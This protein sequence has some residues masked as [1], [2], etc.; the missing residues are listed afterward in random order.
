M[1]ATTLRVTYNTE[2]AKSLGG[3]VNKVVHTIR[4]YTEK[5]NL[6]LFRTTL[7]LDDGSVI[8]CVFVHGAVIVDVNKPS[9]GVSGKV[10]KVITEII[11]YRFGIDL[12]ASEDKRFYVSLVLGKDD[13]KIGEDILARPQNDYTISDEYYIAPLYDFI[14][15][16]CPSITKVGGVQYV[17]VA[18][19]NVELSPVDKWDDWHWHKYY[20]D[21]TPDGYEMSEELYRPPSKVTSDSGATHFSM[22]SNT[23]FR[24]HEIVSRYIDQTKRQYAP[25]KMVTVAGAENMESINNSMYGRN[26][27]TLDAKGNIT[28]KLERVTL[29]SVVTP[30]VTEGVSA[31]QFFWPFIPYLDEI[32]HFNL[33]AFTRGSDVKIEP[34]LESMVSWKLHYLDAFDVDQSIELYSDEATFS[35][36]IPDGES[37]STEEPTTCLCAVAGVETFDGLICGTGSIV[38]TSDSSVA[39]SSSGTKYVPIGTGGSLKTLHVKNDWVIA[40]TGPV[41]SVNTTSVTTGNLPVVFH[42]IGQYIDTWP[43]IFGICDYRNDSTTDETYTETASNSISITQEL[44]FGDDIIDTGITTMQYSMNYEEERTYTGYWEIKLDGCASSCTGIIGYTTTQM[45]VGDTQTLTVVDAVTGAT[46]SWAITAGGGSLSAATG[47][48]TVY[49][50]PATNANCSS[51]PTISLSCEIAAVGCAEGTASTVVDTL[52]IA[53]NANATTDYAYGIK[54]NYTCGAPYSNGDYWCITVSVY[55]NE[56]K[57]DGTLKPAGAWICTNIKS[58]GNACCRKACT[59]TCAD[60]DASIAY[61]FGVCTNSTF[62]LPV[63]GGMVDLRTAAMITAGCCPAALM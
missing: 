31:I 11:F 14:R 27:Y 61:P 51:N 63:N 43:G 47:T 10:E 42:L 21:G 13:Y 1:G 26:P 48:S 4:S 46:Y 8:K 28:S 57:C 3:L 19:D 12:I 45:A 55:T 32:G 59:I 62:A 34:N 56:Y 2:E 37:V 52:K 9:F 17:T 5:A 58:T 16:N 29:G 25:A 7:T 6:D 60:G 50:A 53:V 38:G 40:G 20:F 41:V 54:S 30:V 39:Y 22:L 24:D 36:G 33:L 35:G 44:K 15:E 23:A 18:P 49:T